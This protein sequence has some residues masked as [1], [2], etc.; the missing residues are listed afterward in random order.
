MY[1]HLTPWEECVP[2]AR[3]VFTSMHQALSKLGMSAMGH[4]AF[5]ERKTWH[6]NVNNAQVNI[7]RLLKTPALSDVAKLCCLNFY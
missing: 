7:F 3:N 5:E 2:P 4:A 6:F 1:S